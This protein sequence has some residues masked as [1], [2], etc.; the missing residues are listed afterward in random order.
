MELT[1]APGW[2]DQFVKQNKL[3]ESKKEFGLPTDAPDWFKPTNN[4]RELVPAGPDQGSVYYE[5]T[6]AGKMFIYEVQL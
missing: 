5:D 6:V 4:F 3:I 1:A 2:R